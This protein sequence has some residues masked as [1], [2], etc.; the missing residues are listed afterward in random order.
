MAK[1]PNAPLEQE[2][3]KCSYM[4]QQFYQTTKFITHIRPDD[5]FSQYVNMGY[6]N[7]KI[8]GRPLPDLAVLESYIY[9]MVKPEYQNEARLFISLWLTENIRHFN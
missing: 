1:N 5:L 6:S 7:F 3:F 8:E 9:Y 2:D 4:E